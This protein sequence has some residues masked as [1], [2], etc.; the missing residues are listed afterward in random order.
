MVLTSLLW[1][2]DREILFRTQDYNA[3]FSCFFEAIPAEF[4]SQS[5]MLNIYVHIIRYCLILKEFLPFPPPCFP[6]FLMITADKSKEMQ[7]LSSA[8]KQIHPHIIVPGFSEP[9][10]PR[11]GTTF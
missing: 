5:V 1:V 7:V 11:F 6:P 8:Q 3:F 10:F 4:I 2:T 9:P